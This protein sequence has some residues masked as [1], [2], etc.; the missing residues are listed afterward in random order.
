MREG[1]RHARL[2][3]GLT[4]PPGPGFGRAPVPRSEGRSAMEHEIDQAAR[5]FRT[6]VVS[7]VIGATLALGTAV[8]LVLT[9][10]L[11][12]WVG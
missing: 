1:R 3:L 5:N 7:A 12:V 11:S 4:D 2:R 9:H 10:H 6:V 8:G